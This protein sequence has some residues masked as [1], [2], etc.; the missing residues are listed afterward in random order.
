MVTSNKKHLN[1]YNQKNEQKLVQELVEEAIKIHSINAVYIPRETQKIDPL[2]R[3]DVLS[4]FTD[5]HNV[6]IY[7]KNVD[8]FDGDST[9]FQKFGLE[10]KNQITVLI[11]RSS[12][13]KIFGK[14]MSRPKEGD[15]LYIPLSIA[16][17]LFEIRFVKED[18]VFY[19]LGDFYVF[20]LQCEQ[21]AFQD[22]QIDTA[23]DEIDEIADEG[24][25]SF[26]LKLQNNT[27]DQ[28]IE[29]EI[30][31]QGESELSANSKAV[32][33][34]KISNNEIK[35]KDMLGEFLP[36][37]TV[38]TTISNTLHTLAL[39]PK[40]NINDSDKISIN[41]ADD[42]GAKNKEFVVI[43]F[44]ENNPFSDEDI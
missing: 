17:A 9:I 1:L 30:L 23:L 27:A 15:L 34:E 29:G 42:F 19:N 44:S 2:F 39:E 10:I 13:G 21:Y 26:I 37:I 41:I 25:Q 33:V 32:F 7:I 31:F 14:E 40:L 24:S 12:F 35:I 36:N 28:F 16:S 11:S 20:E 38:K 4:K 18:S 22:E 43:D 5:H 6:E 3:E 8:G